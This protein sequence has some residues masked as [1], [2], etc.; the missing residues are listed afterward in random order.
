MVTH[1]LATAFRTSQRFTFLHQSRM[2]FEGTEEEMR[3][4]ELPEVQQFL[5]PTDESLFV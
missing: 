3:G 2:I 5:Q 1:D 4:S